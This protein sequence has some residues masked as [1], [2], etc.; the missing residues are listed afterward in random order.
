[1]F[2]GSDSRQCW[3]H[4]CKK[5]QGYFRNGDHPAIYPLTC[6]YCGVRTA[7]YNFLTPAQCMYIKTYIDK[8]MEAFDFEPEP[9]TEQEFV[10]DMDAI[11]DLAADQPRPEFYY[12]SETQQTSYRCERC[13]R[14]N[15]I[16]GK[17]G[18]C[19]SCGWRNNA[20]MLRGAFAELRERLNAGH[21]VPADTIKSAVSEFDAS[22]RDMTAQIRKRIR[23]KPAR[24]AELERLL[25]HNIESPSIGTMKSMFDIDLLRSL[26]QDDL[27]FVKMMMHRRH[28][29]EHN[30]GVADRRYVEESGDPAAREGD[31][32]RESQANS[33]R[34]LGRLVR[35]FENFDSDFHEIFPPTQW[36]IDWH[37]E[38][39]RQT[40]GQ[41]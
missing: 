6:P 16:R 3:G 1:V 20:Q 36:P 33:H 4:Q 18:Y 29:F 30:A 14:F 41:T 39:L 27:A 37:Q 11:V 21:S 22:C 26:S 32:I 34:L 23:M 35:M 5:C 31:L 9:G 25:F 19:A 13:N 7:A 12:A 28:I 15:D 8:L 10:I 2:L 24:R 17:Y 38:H 40:E